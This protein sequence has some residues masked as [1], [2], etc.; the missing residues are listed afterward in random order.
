MWRLVPG[1]LGTPCETGLD[2]WGWKVLGNEA[3]EDQVS[4][5]R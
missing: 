3:G 5:G 1:V 4:Q 2:V